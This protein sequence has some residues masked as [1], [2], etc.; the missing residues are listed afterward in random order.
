GY[1]RAGIF[2]ALINGSILIA[3]AFLIIYEAYLRLQQP[4]TVQGPL[5]LAIAAIGLLGNL[6]IDGLLSRLGGANLNVRGVFLHTVGESLSS[7]DG[8]VSS[9]IVI[10]TGYQ[11]IDSLAAAIIGL[12]I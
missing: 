6:S 9:L 1:H 5:V 8:L 2:A 4:P 3:V 11:V 12:L 10:L 7:V